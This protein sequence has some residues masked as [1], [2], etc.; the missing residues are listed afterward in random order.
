[1]KLQRRNEHGFGGT[2]GLIVR[3][4]CQ[5]FTSLSS[6]L[7]ARCRQDVSDS[8]RLGYTR[9]SCG[10]STTTI[11]AV[12]IRTKN[13]RQALL[14]K[15]FVS[16]AKA[17]TAHRNSG[18]S[19]S[20]LSRASVALVCMCLAMT[21][22][23]HVQIQPPTAS[24]QDIYE[25][26]ASKDTPLRPT[27]PTPTNG[28]TGGPLDITLTCKSLGYT[29]V[30]VY[31]GTTS[32]PPKVA[33]LTGP[34]SW[35]PPMPL[36]PFTTYY[37]RVIARNSI[38]T[39]VGPASGTWSFTT[40]VVQPP[41]PMLKITCPSNVMV[42]SA[43]GGAPV[44]VTFSATTSGGVPPVDLT[45]APASGTLFPIATTPVT[46]SAKSSDGQTAS[47]NFTV[48][49]TYT[50]PPVPVNELVLNGTFESF[51]SGTATSWY[52]LAASGTVYTLSADTMCHTG[53]A[54]KIQVP[55]YGGWG[56]LFG[57]QKTNLVVGSTY[58]WSF[59]YKS[60]VQLYAQVAD[61]S[62]AH[63][64]ADFA[65]APTNG[66]CLLFSQPFTYTDAGANTIRVL[67][68]AAGTF[69]LDDMSLMLSGL[70]PAVTYDVKPNT[71]FSVGADY[72][73]NSVMANGFRLYIDGQKKSETTTTPLTFPVTG[74]V[75]AGT[76]AVVVSS[77]AVVNAVELE[78]QSAPV[79]ISVGP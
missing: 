71:T 39:I 61:D 62:Y 58:V 16:G 78:A 65:L 46:A 20:R 5:W 67:P 28:A 32:N 37:W 22:T 27:N 60:D 3:C 48:T 17:L 26:Q 10:N 40:G 13:A 79:Q 52:A 12:P 64:S 54:Q 30:D 25:W 45:Y 49:V 55:T 11:D 77:Y 1:M 14:L 43:P 66:Q 31:L 56:M 18:T 19:W 75:P 50:P 44:A 7:A 63:H 24:T 70:P 6:S 53:Q 38:G 23:L 4:R 8:L 29:S 15:Q 76:H 36:A 35:K 9:A 59:W 57:Q 72:L 21:A 34:C 68:A 2:R 42:A 47:C 73:A 33:T 69:W 74:G 51:T 41:P